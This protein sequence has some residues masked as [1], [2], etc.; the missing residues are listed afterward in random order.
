MTITDLKK[1]AERMNEQHSP[2]DRMQVTLR[3][4]ALSYIGAFLYDRHRSVCR[5]LADPKTKPTKRANREMEKAMLEA[6]IYAI[7][8]PTKL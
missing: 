4:D 3:R 8:N 1:Y 7:N 2:L 5:S 6:S